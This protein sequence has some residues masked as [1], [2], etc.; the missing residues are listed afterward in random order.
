MASE[1]KRKDKRHEIIYEREKRDGMSFMRATCCCEE[2]T[3]SWFW[4]PER[5][6]SA[7]FDHLGG[8]STGRKGGRS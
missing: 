6:E 7:G 1:V 5:A 4:A 3:S 8:V 2:F